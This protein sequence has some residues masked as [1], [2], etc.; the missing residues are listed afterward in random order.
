VLR[1]ANGKSVTE[2]ACGVGINRATVSSFI[3]R[4]NWGGLDSLLRDKTR[5]NGIINF[6]SNEP[7]FEPMQRLRYRAEAH[8]F[9]FGIAARNYKRRCTAYF[10]LTHLRIS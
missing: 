5:K 8:F 10:C 1:R 4:Y 7:P 2:V 3:N 9:E 6:L